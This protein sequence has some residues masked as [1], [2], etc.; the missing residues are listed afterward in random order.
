M[1]DLKPIALGAATACAALL[2]GCGGGSG[3]NMNSTARQACESIGGTN[4]PGVGYVFATP[5]DAEGPVPNF[6]KISGT[7]SGK[8]NFELRLPE[9]WNGKLHYGGGG[10]YNGAIPGVSENILIALKRGY[11]TVS[12]DSGHQGS[13]FDASFALNDP[14]A[15]Q[16]FGSQSVPAVMAAAQSLLRTA[17]NAAPTRSYFEGCSNGGREALMSA[18]RNPTLFDGI[19]ARAPAYNWAGLMGAFNRTSKALAAPGGQFSN[20]KIQLLAGAV[21]NACDGLDGIN[22]GVVSNQA[23][24][25]AAVFDASALRCAGGGDAGDSCLSDAQLGVVGSWV[26]PAV[27]AGGYRNAGWNLTGNE[28]DEGAWPLWET[29]NGKLGNALQFLFQDTTVKNYLAR[30][31]AANS[32]TYSPYDRNPAALKAMAE[33]NDATSTDLRPFNNRGAQLILWHGGNDAALSVNSTSEYYAGVVS[34]VGGQASADA[35]VRYYVAP[36]VNHC[37]GGL[38]ADST[39]LLGALDAWVTKGTPPETLTAQKLATDG[40]TELTRPLCRH[41]L[42][43]RYTGPANNAAAAKLAANYV[44]AAS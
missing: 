33:L 10:G 21:R 13:V 22:D 37:T 11:A 25:S 20:A 6:C 27:F 36:G 18:Q 32:L 7:L 43:P 42:Y 15:A 1:I 29:G 23:A 3:G 16:W 39:D 5:V 35:F 31:P 40:S 34:A 44:C 24:C 19:I 2:V 26:S 41:P 8:L 4:V 30:D 14:Q 38:G 17:Y 9:V 28:D 12:S